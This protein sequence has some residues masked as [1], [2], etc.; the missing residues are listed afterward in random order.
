MLENL[1]HT[2][3]DPNL[4]DVGYLTKG[5]KKSIGVSGEVMLVD[6]A[7]LP[8]GGLESGGGA[9]VGGTYIGKPTNGDFTTAYASGTTITL[10]LPTGVTA[11][12]DEDIEFVRQINA[13]GTVV[14]TYMR[15]ETPMT[16]TANVL[17]VPAATFAATDTFVV[18]TNIPRA[19]A[20]GAGG[21]GG[22]SIVYTN[23]AGDFIATPT[24]GAAT[25]TITG[26]PFTLEAINVIG[27][28]IKKK[29]VTTNLVTT[30][31]PSSISVSSGVITLGGIANFATGDEVYVTLIG[32]DKAYDLPLDNTLVA[33]QNP[34]YA[35]TTSVEALIA[36]TNL[37]GYKA[38]A[39]AGGDTDTIVDADGAFSV[40]THAV[41]YI[42]YQTTDTQSA[43]VNSVASATTIETTTLSGAA[44]WLS[45]AYSLP[46]VKRYEI[47]MDT[48]NF[49]TIHY[50]L[51]CLTFCNAY[52]KIWGTLDPAATVDATTGWVD[53][54]LP[55]LGATAGIIV[56]TSLTT[57]ME[58]IVILDTPTTMQKY[59]ISIIVE[60]NSASPNTNSFYVWVKK[61]S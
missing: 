38:T 18:G 8:I 9:S 49:L 23:A 7:G 4:K 17:S 60:S 5:G 13:A 29:S 2:Q 12:T 26:L 30:L 39:D 28:S 42:A 56:P 24:N 44:T 33:V 36:E 3:L 16:V 51:R 21:A 43:T 1:K 58:D 6:S 25:I 20:G 53:L 46:M 48:Y 47:N 54:S 34:Q 31:N 57:I 14:A 27:G 22:G 55:I 35:H 50:R 15:D 19:D 11:F 61:S 52:M 45:K 10:G 32:P 59:M 41:G 40:A 37:L